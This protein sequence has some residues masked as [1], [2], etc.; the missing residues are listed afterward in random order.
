MQHPFF[1]DL[2]W[3]KVK[4]KEHEMIFKPRVRHAEDTSCIDKMFTRETL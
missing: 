1:A 4:N 2:D 3:E